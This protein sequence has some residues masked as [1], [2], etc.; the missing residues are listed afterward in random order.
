FYVRLQY[1]LFAGSAI[2]AI[3]LLGVL[4]TTTHDK[5][6]SSLNSFVTPIIS[7]NQ[8]LTNLVSSSGGYYNYVIQTAN[9]PTSSFSLGN[10][11]LL[12]GIIWISFGYAFWSIYNLGEIKRAS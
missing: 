9:F 7:S 5:F 12:F 6:V 11:L 10:T 8:T 3:T 2:S 1:L 4:A